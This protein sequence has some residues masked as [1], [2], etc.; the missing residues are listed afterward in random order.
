M[1]RD[2]EVDDVW[3]FED[4]YNLSLEFIIDRSIRME[5]IY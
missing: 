3:S 1:T 5:G 4:D 2:E